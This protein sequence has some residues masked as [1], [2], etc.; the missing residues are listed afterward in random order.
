[1]MGPGFNGHINNLCYEGKF[2]YAMCY[3]G[4]ESA[5]EEETY[6]PIDYR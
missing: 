4:C 6:M 3:F 1:M 5:L 2:L